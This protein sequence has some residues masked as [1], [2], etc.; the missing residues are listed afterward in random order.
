MLK[1]ETLVAKIGV[2]IAENEAWKGSGNVPATR[3]S[4][5]SHHISHR[6]GLSK[7]ASSCAVSFRIGWMRL[8]TGEV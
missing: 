1:N 2:D 8:L 3:L 4:R 5:I 7:L 6:W